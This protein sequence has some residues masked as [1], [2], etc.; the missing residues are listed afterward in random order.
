MSPVAEHHL[1]R[2]AERSYERKGDYP[3]L[4]FEGRWHES[5]ELFARA[6]R[7]AAGLGESG[8]SEGE[9]VVVTMAGVVGRPSPVHGEEVVLVDAV[10]LTAV[11]K[12][13]R[14]VLRTRARELM[15]DPAS[16]SSP[17]SSA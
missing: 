10:P 11:G 9:R 13:D 6:R 12:I 2:L 4:L 3:S 1:G 16:F 8:V 15:P 14:K 17:S 7:L 5:G